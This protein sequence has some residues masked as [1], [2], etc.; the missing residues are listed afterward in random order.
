[1]PNGDRNDN[2]LALQVEQVSHSSSSPSTWITVANRKLCGVIASSFTCSRGRALWELNRKDWNLPLSKLDKLLCGGYLILSDYAAGT[3]PPQFLDEAAAH[4]AEID[5]TTSL[6][7]LSRDE[8]MTSSLRKPFWNSVAFARYARH[9]AYLLRVFEELGLAPKN[10]LLE[11]G[12]GAGWMAEFLALY[13][14]VL[15]GTSICPDDITVAQQRMKGVEGRGIVGCLRFVRCPMESVDEHVRDETPF[16]GVFVYEALHH[17]FDWRRAIQATYHCL[18]P[19][20][21]LV[22]A[23][24]PN[25]LHTFVSY[26]V[27]KLSNT[28]EI[29][30]HRKQLLAHLAACGFGEARIFKPKPDN[31]ITPHWLA[32]RRLR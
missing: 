13:G 8:A 11:L 20:G 6:P 25:R 4:Q 22:L 18:R 15:T 23:N 28:H 16:D 27:A 10:R 1:L 32:A 5:Y 12:C 21:W 2:P 7:G 29:G 30:F 17:A 19:G 31:F 3:F 24:E 9:F 26:R 14:Y